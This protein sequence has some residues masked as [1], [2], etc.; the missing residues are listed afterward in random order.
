MYILYKYRCHDCDHHG[1][2][3]FCDS[4]CDYKWDVLDEVEKLLKKIE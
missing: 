1:D 2:D 4:S 3:G